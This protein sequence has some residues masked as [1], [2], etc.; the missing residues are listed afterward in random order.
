MP[1]SGSETCQPRWGL[2]FHLSSTESLPSVEAPSTTICSQSSKPDCAPNVLSS[3][4][5]RPGALLRL[6]VTMEIFT[7]SS[8]AQAP[9]SR[10]GNPVSSSDPSR[11]PGPLVVQC[12]QSR[13]DT[14]PECR[15]QQSAQ[16]VESDACHIGDAGRNH[17]RNQRMP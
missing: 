14:F 11:K 5:A 10:Q 2:A 6:I 16:H 3:V 15:T 4:R 9:P 8:L 13:I 7:G 17:H 12:L 1:A